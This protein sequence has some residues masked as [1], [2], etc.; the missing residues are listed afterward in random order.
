MPCVISNQYPQEINVTGNVLQ[1][2]LNDSVDNWKRALLCAEKKY[3]DRE[4]AFFAVNQSIFDAKVSGS[5][6]ESLYGDIISKEIGG[7]K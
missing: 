5:V 2:P 7:K 4:E 6:L 1:V 3:V